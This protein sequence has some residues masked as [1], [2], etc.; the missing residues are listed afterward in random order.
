MWLAALSA[1][2]RIGFNDRTPVDS[3]GGVDRI[4]DA[5]AS[6]AA[7][8]AVDDGCAPNAIEA[9]GSY[10]GGGV[11]FPLD[12]ND[13]TMGVSD[14]GVQYTGRCTAACPVPAAGAQGIGHG[15]EFAGAQLGIVGL[16]EPDDKTGYTVAVWARL[17]SFPPGDTVDTSYACALAKP[18]ATVPHAAPS[19]D[20]NSYA[21]C[22]DL[23]HRVYVY[24]TSDSAAVTLT[25]AGPLGEIARTGQW[26]HLATTL[27]AACGRQILYVDGCRVN[28]MAGVE[29]RFDPSA[30]FIGAD[31]LGTTGTAPT[32]FW[33]GVLDEVLLYN[34]ALTDAEVKRLAASR[35]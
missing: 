12:E 35:L 16:P 32:Y 4:P 18:N 13:P 14:V 30:V 26:H 5:Q 3:N 34:R 23:T 19:N 25:A 8:A 11:W 24:T 31:N 21:L 17:D 6:C 9:N 2:G 15:L 7:L 20:G 29:A 27:D 22:V 1:C 33:S 10:P 28:A